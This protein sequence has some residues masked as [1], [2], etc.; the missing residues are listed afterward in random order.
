MILFGV[1]LLFFKIAGFIINDP[2]YFLLPKT[3]NTV[4]NASIKRKLL[5]IVIARNG[6]L[7]FC[8]FIPYFLEILSV[9]R[10][11]KKFLIMLK[12]FFKFH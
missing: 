6:K 10:S 12:P 8:F 1:V 9:V 11:F 7:N 3:K 5:D 2:E 4:M